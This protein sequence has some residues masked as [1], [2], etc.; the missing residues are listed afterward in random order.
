MLTCVAVMAAFLAMPPPEAGIARVRALEMPGVQPGDYFRVADPPELECRLRRSFLLM[1]GNGDGFI[2][3]PE[4]PTAR[5]VWID[6]AGK[7]I[8]EE[9]PTFW[10]DE[11]DTDGDGRVDWPEMREALMPGLLAAAR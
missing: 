6:P 5:R 4:I 3:G 10:S 2:S 7:V 1:D 11:K 9:S 8:R